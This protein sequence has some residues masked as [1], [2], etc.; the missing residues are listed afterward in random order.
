MTREILELILKQAPGFAA[1]KEGW[2][3]EAEHR[4]TLYL[5]LG[6]GST[7]LAE[8]SKVTLDKEFLRV[9][10]RDRSVHFL[11][12]EHVAG[13]SSRPP[14]ETGAASRTGF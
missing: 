13:V 10:V 4:A 2:S 9:E 6:Q 8:I 11:R 7:S 12:Y 5:V 3:V 14:R 1:S